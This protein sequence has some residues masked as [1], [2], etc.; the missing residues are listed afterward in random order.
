MMRL[1]IAPRRVRTPTAARRGRAG[2][3]HTDAVRDR[4]AQRCPVLPVRLPMNRKRLRPSAGEHDR[5][6]VGVYDR[7]HP[8]RTR[9]VL[10]PIVVFVVVAIAYA[11]WFYLR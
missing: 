8:M 11:L 1:A 3:G 9:K 5:N 4:A 2:F 10:V 6:A 7:P